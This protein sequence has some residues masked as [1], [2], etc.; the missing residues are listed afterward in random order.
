[1]W[2]STYPHNG[3]THS[4]DE[5][6]I[7]LPAFLSDFPT[8]NTICWKRHWFF[9]SESLYGK[10]DINNVLFWWEEKYSQ[11]PNELTDI[12]DNE[13]L[14]PYLNNK[15]KDI[16]HLKHKNIY[17]LGEYIDR[18]WIYIGCFRDTKTLFIYLNEDSFLFILQYR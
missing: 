11:F 18:K 8:E 2:L 5:S 6:P 1:L 10:C 15:L 13:Q 17:V 4:L 7:E 12:Y 16:K 14:R 3:T 9:R